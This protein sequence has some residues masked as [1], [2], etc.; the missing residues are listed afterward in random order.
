MKNRREM[1][2]SV[3]EHWVAQRLTVVT[4]RIDTFLGGE[5][6]LQKLYKTRVF[7]IIN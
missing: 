5:S 1:I 7:E 2:L 6:R 3:Q 4:V